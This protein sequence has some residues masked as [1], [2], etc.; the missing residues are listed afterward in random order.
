MVQRL[1]VFL[2]VYTHILFKR[3]II[4]ISTN[5]LKSKVDHIRITLWEAKWECKFK[6][7]KGAQVFDL[8][9]YSCIFS[10]DDSRY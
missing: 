5:S 10:R 3:D 1:K 2:F 8:T 9:A 6:E 4:R 7:K